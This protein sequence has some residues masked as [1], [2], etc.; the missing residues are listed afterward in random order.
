MLLLL[1]GPEPL[2]VAGPVLSAGAQTP[3]PTR[4]ASRQVYSIFHQAG[5]LPIL[6][7]PNHFILVLGGGLWLFGASVLP[8][9]R[10]V[11]AVR[12]RALALTHGLG[13]YLFAGQA[14]AYTCLSVSGRSSGLSPEC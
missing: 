14:E 12:E 6:S 10:V 11:T 5:V 3:R 4:T 1:D 7:L 9:V 2:C 8:Y 13:L